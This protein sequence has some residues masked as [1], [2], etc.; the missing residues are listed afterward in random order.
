MDL[1]VTNRA[2]LPM[3]QQIK[4]QIIEA[5][6]NDKIEEG[7]ALD[8]IRVLANKTRVSVITVMR[9]YTDLEDEGYIISQPGKGYYVADRNN[10]LFRERLIY[11]IRTHIDQAIVVAKRLG[12]SNNEV[13]RI[14]QNELGENVDGKCD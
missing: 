1:R 5:I 8:S 12:I 10:E 9:A 4:N 11:S 7:E 13:I 3:Y 14:L 2:D 6:I